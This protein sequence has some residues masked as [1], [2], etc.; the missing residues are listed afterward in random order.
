MCRPRA[1]ES[2]IGEWE[3]ASRF[4]SHYL[5]TVQRDA[6]DSYGDEY[7]WVYCLKFLPSWD[8]RAGIFE[9]YDFSWIDSLWSRKQ[10]Q[11]PKEQ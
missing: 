4:S 3:R 7:E 10:L 5:G 2:Q 11:A 9:P 8:L 6:T 1:S